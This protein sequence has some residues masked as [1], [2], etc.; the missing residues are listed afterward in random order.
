MS[1]K[2]QVFPQFSWMLPQQG[3]RIIYQTGFSFP[4]LS[5]CTSE[6]FLKLQIHNFL[7]MEYQKRRIRGDWRR[8]QESFAE[9]VSVLRYHRCVSRAPPSNYFG[10]CIGAAFRKKFVHSAGLLHAPQTF[11]HSADLT[12]A[13]SRSSNEC[14]RLAEHVGNSDISS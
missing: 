10:Y 8:L 12:I 6:P 4:V 2:F 14:C 11:V 1:F 7:S 5:L 9:Q 3:T 13:A